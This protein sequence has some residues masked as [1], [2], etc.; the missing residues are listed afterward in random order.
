METNLVIPFQLSS[1]NSDNGFSPNLSQKLERLG[2]NSRKLNTKKLNFGSTK[3]N[4][5]KT[6]VIGRVHQSNQLISLKNINEKLSGLSKHHFG[7]EYFT[8]GSVIKQEK[9]EP[10]LPSDRE[11]DSI[12]FHMLMQSSN[13]DNSN[14][15]N[16]FS[17]PS[18]PSLKQ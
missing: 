5:L 2:R 13:E 12:M 15:Y 7:T 11:N 17:N 1:S 16:S 3:V 18:Y 9:W 4:I 8:N 6:P 10:K 14:S